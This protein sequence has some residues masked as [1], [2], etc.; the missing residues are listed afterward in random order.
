MLSKRQRRGTPGT[1]PA[2][3]WSSLVAPLRC[4]QRLRVGVD[5]NVEQGGRAIFRRDDKEQTRV[6]GTPFLG[7]D[8][9]PAQLLVGGAGCPAP[10][11][12]ARRPAFGRHPLRR[13]VSHHLLGRLTRG[14][15]NEF[16]FP[17]GG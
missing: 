7:E 6:Q 16:E 3:S 11:L 10:R 12:V 4:R 5:P 8:T 9:H 13:V 17:S 15:G 14:V 1:A 2:V